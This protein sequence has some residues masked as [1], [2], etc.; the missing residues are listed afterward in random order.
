MFVKKSFSGGVEVPHFKNTENIQTEKIGVP[1]EVI[2]PMQQHSGAPCKLTVKEGEPVKVGQVIGISESFISAPI[3]SSVSGTVADISSMIF[4]DGRYVATVVIKADG[5]Q[6]IHEDVKPPICTNKEEFIEAVKNSGLVGLGGAGFP[7]HV[8]L[9]PPK[10]KN[11]DTLIINAAECEPFI[12][13]D[14]RE[15]MENSAD[16]MDGIDAVTKFIGVSNVII[17]IEDN[18]PEAISLLKKLAAGKKGI[19]VKALRTRYPQGAEK[20]LI[21]ALT[22]RKVPPGKLPMDVG[23]IVMNITSV[24]FVGRYLKDGMPLIKKRVTV[25]GSAVNRPSNVEA[26]I[27]TKLSDVFDF[28]GGFKTE[29]F[30]IIMGGPMMGIAQYT[31]DAPVMKYTNALLAFDKT[32]GNVPPETACIRCGRCYRACPVNLMPLHINRAALVEDMDALH[33]YHTMDCIECGCCAYS[34]PARIPLV[35]SIRLGKTLIKKA[36]AKAKKDESQKDVKS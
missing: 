23:V 29:P 24:G 14:Y 21:Y 1:D 12:T 32:F 6:D 20:M 8:K 35:Q 27:G 26:L 10:D 7:A 28:C 13:S 17:G 4:P 3:H 25:D 34:C 31:L 33:K 2:I 36:Q 11:I 19:D 15:I 5:K 16:I 9:N 18:K 22:G 30:K